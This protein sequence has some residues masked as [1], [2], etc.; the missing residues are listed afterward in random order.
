MNVRRTLSVGLFGF[1]LLVGSSVMA[2]EPSPVRVTGAWI[3]EAPPVST[4]LAGYATLENASDNPVAIVGGS[5]PAFARVEIHRTRIT[6]G[7]ARMA[8][9]ER[10]EIPGGGRVAFEPGG[11]HLMLIGPARVL[12]EGDEVEVTLELEDGRTIRIRATVS[13]RRPE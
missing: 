3:R 13:S 12:A 6:D 5:S 4:M 7:L 1:L 8:R 10:V 2:T 11:Y 9:Q